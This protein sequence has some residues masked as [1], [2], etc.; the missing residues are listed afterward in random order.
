MEKSR[1]K[2]LIQKVFEGY[3]AYGEMLHEYAVKNLIRHLE[4]NPDASFESMR[5]HFSGGRETAWVNLG[6]QI[7]REA[8]V[9]QLRADIGGGKLATWED[10]HARYDALWEAY[11]VEKQRHAYQ[12]LCALLG[13]ERPSHAQWFAAL[14]RAV[15]IQELIRD[16]VYES[17]KKDFD[18]PFRR[19][20]YRNDDE[21]AAAIGTVEDNEF[22]RLVREE[23]DA[24]IRQVALLKKRE[25]ANK[26]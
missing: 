24:F 16:R 6:G 1:R 4:T 3:R 15:E 12:T 23:T 11:P 25:K 18:N 9:A 21:M 13:T 10:I 20:T 2:V 19:V 14:D 7:M 8:D 26:Q 5:R 17:R 22:V